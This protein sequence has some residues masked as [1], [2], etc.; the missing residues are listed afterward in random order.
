MSNSPI[1]QNTS[2]RRASLAA[3]LVGAAIGVGAT[4]FAF[5]G[6]SRAAGNPPPL[7]LSA[8][9]PATPQ[10]GFASLVAKVKPAVVQIA[11]T[12]RPEMTEDDQDGQR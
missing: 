10:S 4:S 8:P 2:V 11:T 9:A 3:L 7:V 6:S 5:S 1:P 12:S